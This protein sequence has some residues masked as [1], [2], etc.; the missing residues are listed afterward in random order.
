[1]LSNAEVDIFEADLEE[2]FTNYYNVVVDMSSITI[3]ETIV[4]VTSQSISDRGN[5]VVYDQ[6]IVYDP[7]D[8]SPPPGD[9]ATEPY[10]DTEQVEVLIQELQEGIP[11]FNNVTGPV[12]VTILSQSMDDSSLSSPVGAI[13][14]GALAGGGGTLLLIAITVILCRKKRDKDDSHKEAVLDNIQ[15]ER[16]RPSS[17][18]L[19]NCGVVEQGAH[20]NVP[21]SASEV[22]QPIRNIKRNPQARGDKTVAKP[23]S[24][25]FS[26]NALYEAPRS[27]NG[28][29]EFD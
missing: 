13:V 7:S 26:W 10:R 28:G 24:P 25:V 22:T 5:T 15:L 23:R 12:V 11:A 14:G 6:A 3:I 1:M 17:D 21:N 16:Q 27:Q 2:W 18:T 29:A 9:I 20:P 4:D 8:K 19:E